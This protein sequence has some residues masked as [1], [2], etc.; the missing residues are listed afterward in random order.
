MA[1]F[2]KA[3]SKIQSLAHEIVSGLEAHPDI[4]PNPPVSAKELE[5][6]L[7]AYMEAADDAKDKQAAAS[8]AIDLKN[9]GLERVVDEAKR[10]LRYAENV[11]DSDDAKL[12]YLGWGGRRPA[13]ALESPGQTRSLEAPRRGA[14]WIFLDW[15]APDEGG[16]VAAYKVQRREEGSEEWIDVGTAIETEATLSGQPGGKQFVFRVVAI[17]KAGEGEPSNGVLATL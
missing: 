11:T 3:E 15:K 10:I 4:F 14:G 8:H 16:K 2:P 17:N 7:N 5:K 12:K 1:Q 6:E 9:E 13:S